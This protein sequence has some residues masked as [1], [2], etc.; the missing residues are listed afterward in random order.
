MA[1]ITF[2]NLDG[3]GTDYRSVLKRAGHSV[4]YL[5]RQLL[6]SFTEL[7]QNDYFRADILI[8][9]SHL[10]ANVNELVKRIRKAPGYGDTP[11]FLMGR[12]E[13]LYS[14]NNPVDR[15]VIPLPVASGKSLLFALERVLQLTA[16]SSTGKQQVE[17][18]IRTIEFPSEYY[19]SGITILSYFATV[20]HHKKLSEDAKISIEQDGRIIRLIIESSSGER[21][22]IERTLDTYALVVTGK[23]S[24]EE[25]TT[26][27]YEIMELR[28]QLRVAYAQLHNQRDLIEFSKAEI[29]Y[30]KTEA[31]EA[32]TSLAQI[33][34]RAEAQSSRFFSL[35]E[36]LISHSADISTAFQQ[37]V[38][39]V[40]VQQN[41]S[42]ADAL[43]SLREMV[44]HGLSE[45]DREEFMQKIEIIRS[46]DPSVFTKVFD[47][48]IKGGISGA[49]GN[50]LYSWL[51]ALINSLPK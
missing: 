7:I 19:H 3:Y 4:Q 27:P 17:R 40:T 8:L 12:F 42:L 33:E 48:L 44:E 47:V 45:R 36:G 30:L 9:K 23:R 5:D 49:T 50:Y 10:D 21:E 32:K 14:Q 41:T 51:Q 35:L 20:L 11:I 29:G 16:H 15:N 39:Q 24:I 34:K 18:I 13:Y 46:E 28:S 6:N 37:L 31:A 1:N 2:I 22:L 43:K 25:L 26:D 38:E